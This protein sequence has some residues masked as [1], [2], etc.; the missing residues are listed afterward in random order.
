M[1]NNRESVGRNPIDSCTSKRM[2]ELP[3]RRM[4]LSEPAAGSVSRQGGRRQSARRRGL[5]RQG[6]QPRRSPARSGNEDGSSTRM[7]GSPGSER[8][9]RG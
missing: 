3:V 2:C 8:P 9:L 5:D 1:M 6:P 7:V 4:I